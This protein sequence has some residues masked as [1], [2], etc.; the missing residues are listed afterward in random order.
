MPCDCAV[1]WRETDTGGVGPAFGVDETTVALL[2]SFPFILI[3][4]LFAWAPGNCE[5]SV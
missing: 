4:L 2:V 5:R 3:L 1:G